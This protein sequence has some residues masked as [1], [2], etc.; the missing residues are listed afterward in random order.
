MFSRAD[1]DQLRQNL[2]SIDF[3]HGATQ[4]T[5]DLSKI[6]KELVTAYRRQYGLDQPQ[7]DAQSEVHSHRSNMGKFNSGR[8]EIVCQH[9]L[10]LRSPPKKTAFVLHGYFDHAGLYRHLI[11]QLLDQDIAVVI[12]DLPGHGLS[13]GAQASIKS[14]REYSETLLDCLS[15]ARQQGVTEPW[16]VIGQSTGAAI[17]MDALLDKNLR[18]A[19]SFHHYVLLGPLL[20]P[21]HWSRSK[22]LFALTRW[23]VPA[24][25]RKFSNNSHDAEFV[26]FLEHSD[27]LQSKI[28]PREWVL[29]MID[30][31]KRF[32]QAA[33][34]AQPLEIIQGSGDG[35]VDWEKNIPKILAKFPG[36]K[37]HMVDGARHHLLNESKPYRAQVLQT[38]R[39]I[40]EIEKSG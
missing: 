39:Q 28:L 35:T 40:L 2:P 30:Y 21:R 34:L 25:S 17:I 13:S 26:E 23:F 18:Q 5:P 14:F 33:T 32:D 6:A 11:R 10:P 12:F 7:I 29:A 9:F 20:R 1:A 31:F 22:Y 24:T 27:Q 16:V 38:I 36:S 3:L 4:S 19:F 37:V 15:E 8:N